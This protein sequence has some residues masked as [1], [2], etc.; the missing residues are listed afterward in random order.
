MNYFV[1]IGC[2]RDFKYISSVKGCYKVVNRNKNWKDANK[3][4]TSLHKDAHLLAINSAKEQAAVAAML[5]SS[6][7]C[8]F[9]I[10][11]KLHI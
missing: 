1:N 4:C 7:Q 11:I 9:S 8:N 3:H 6:S 5:K 2:P 10:F